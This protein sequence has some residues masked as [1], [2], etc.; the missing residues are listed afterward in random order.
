MCH[1][2]GLQRSCLCKDSKINVLY[3]PSRHFTFEQVQEHKLE[4]NKSECFGDSWDEP[5][6]FNLHYPCLDCI[7]L[8]DTHS[9]QISLRDVYQVFQRLE[10]EAQKK[11]CATIGVVPQ[12][13]DTTIATLLSPED[14]NWL[15]SFVLSLRY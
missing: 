12:L 6:I 7:N 1:L 8:D 13:A 5:T 15:Q 2:F 9:L 14:S 4:E 10:A 11:N 3:C